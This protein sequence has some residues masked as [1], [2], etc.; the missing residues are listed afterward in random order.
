MFCDVC[1]SP[2]G[3]K[4]AENCETSSASEVVLVA[5]FGLATCALVPLNAETMSTNIRFDVTVD[6]TWP[7]IVFRKYTVP[8][9]LPII[10]KSSSPQTRFNAMELHLRTAEA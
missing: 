5:N 3:G 10:I 7:A 6:F 1:H 2:N 4:L 9:R 8:A